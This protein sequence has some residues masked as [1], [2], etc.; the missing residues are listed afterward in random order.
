MFLHFSE[1]VD[2]YLRLSSSADKQQRQ[3]I[4]SI[5]ER[6][7]QKSTQ[8]L[9]ALQKKVESY[10]KKIVDIEHGV[11]QHKQPKEVLKDVGQGLKYVWNKASHNMDKKYL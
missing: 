1:H 11:S 3:R 5:F 6:K 4:K 2:E 8:T 9:A 7:N 10:K